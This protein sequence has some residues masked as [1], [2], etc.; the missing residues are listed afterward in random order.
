MSRIFLKIYRQSFMIHWKKGS[1]TMATTITTD[2]KGVNKADF[3]VL[4]D[5]EPILQFENGV[6]VSDTPIGERLIIALQ[7]NQL[8]R[9]AVKFPNDPIPNVSAEM[10]A[11]ATGQCKFMYVKIP[12]CTV[13]LYTSKKQSGLQMTATA[14][15]AQ[16]VT[17]KKNS[18]NE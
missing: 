3:A 15:T 10:I 1:E 18:D 13:D 17:L 11:E 14:I 4:V 16:I 8:K 5:K 6:P 9:L 7:N 12:D 2:L